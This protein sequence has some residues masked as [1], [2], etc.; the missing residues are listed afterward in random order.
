MVSGLFSEPLGSATGFAHVAVVAA[1]FD[2]HA[3]V[4]DEDIAQGGAGADPV[5]EF[6]RAAHH[7]QAALVQDGQLVAQE[8]GFFH[9]V[10]G[11]QDG[12][13]GRGL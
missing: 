6:G 1:L 10:G 5:F 13:A 9:V 8:V 11:E 3:A 4:R 12:H 2:H 7:G